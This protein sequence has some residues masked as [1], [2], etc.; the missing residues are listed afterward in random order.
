MRI[1]TRVRMSQDLKDLFRMNGSHE[2]LREF[3][4][5]VGVVIPKDADIEHWPEVRVRWGD[6]GLNYLYPPSMLEI[7]E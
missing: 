1:G 4:H 5:E 3:E 2:H 6:T 7:V